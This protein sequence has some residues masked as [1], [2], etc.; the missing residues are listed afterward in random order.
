MFIGLFYVSEQWGYAQIGPNENST[1]AEFNF[2]ISF[3]NSALT[4][5]CSGASLNP[6][7]NVETLTT[8]SITIGRTKHTGGQADARW[9]VVGM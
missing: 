2:P 8:N 3:I 5:V 4:G 9:L 7:Y 6:I 1:Y